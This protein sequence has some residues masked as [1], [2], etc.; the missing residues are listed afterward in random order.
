MKVQTRRGTTLRYLSILAGVALALICLMASEGPV[1]AND[2]CGHAWRTVFDPQEVS[3]DIKD[4]Y[5]DVLE[6]RVNRIYVLEMMRAEHDDDLLHVYYIVNRN[7]K[8]YKN[9]KGYLTADRAPI[10]VATYRYS[11]LSAEWVIQRL[12]EEYKGDHI[13]RD[14]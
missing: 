6:Q 5:K 7:P 8:K 1:R 9:R 12:D 14:I 2:F 13:F 10:K 4:Y 11:Y 3:K